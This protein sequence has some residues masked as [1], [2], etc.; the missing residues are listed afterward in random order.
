MNAA[1]RHAHANDS[2]TYDCKLVPDP[3]RAFRKRVISM[4]HDHN[5]RPTKVEL[6]NRES[7]AEATAA[8]WPRRTSARTTGQ[9]NLAS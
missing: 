4:T 7:R 8:I 9:M 6:S 2:Q 1:F 5:A 3:P